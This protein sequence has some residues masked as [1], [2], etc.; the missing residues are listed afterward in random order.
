M[1]LFTIP[2]RKIGFLTVFTLCYLVTKAQTT[3]TWNQAG[4]GNWTTSTNWTPTRTTPATNDILVINNGGTKT[5]TSVPTQTIGRILISGNTN[6]TLTHTANANR[7]ITISN[8]TTAMDIASGSTLTLIGNTGGGTRT[9]TIQFTGSGNAVNIAGNLNLNTSQA[10]EYI[11]TNSVTTV[12]GTITN[13]GG[14]ITSTAANLSFAS[15]GT[16]V[17]ALNGSAIP[18][19]TWNAASNCN[20]TGITATVPTGLGQA[21]GNFTWNCAGHSTLIR[22]DGALTTVNGNF[23]VSDAG[24]FQNPSFIENGLSLTSNNALTLTIGGNFVISNAID[25]TWLILADGNGAVTV[26]VGGNFNM[27]GSTSYFIYH[28]A[29]TSSL[30]N[31]I[32]MNVSGNF[33]QSGGLIDFAYQTSTGATTQSL[34]RVAGNFSHS[35]TSILQ[36][37]TTDTD[38]PNGKIVFNKAGTQ[39]FSAATPANIGYTN[40]E[41][42]SGSTVELLSNVSLSSQATPAIWGGKFTVNS[43][44]ILDAG[45]FQLVSSTGATAGL[46]NE[47]TLSSSAGLITA[48]VNGIQNTTIGTISTSLATRTYSSAANYTYDG[49]AIQNSGIFT[50]SPTANQ[51]NNLTLNNTAGN[52][53]TGV[54]LQ[55]AFAVAGTLTLT[56]GHITSSSTNL[57]TMNAGSNVAGANYGTRISG[58]SDNSFVNGPIRKIGNTNFLFPVGK[59]N[60][61]HHFA[62][63]SSP[64]NPGD[65]YTTE[66]IRGSA[67]LLGTVSAVG[68]SHVSNCE[69]WDISTT[70]GSPNVD[71]TLSWTGTS[72]CNAAVYVNDLPSL[73]AAHFS[74]GTWS[75]YGGTVDGGSTASAGSLTWNGVT[76]FSPFSLGSTDKETNPLPV[77]LVNVKAYRSGNRNKIEWTNLTETAVDVYEVQRSVTGTSFET[78][79]SVAARSNTN[80]REDYF[81]FDPQT[82]P[83]TYYR[84]KVIGNDGKISYSPVVK[85]NG[86]DQDQ[87]QLVLYPNP[88]TGK[89]FTI[90]MNSPAG[91]Y[92]V[93][94]FGANGQV[95]KMETLKHPGGAYS[96]TIELPSQLQAGQYYLQVSGG[97]QMLT[98]KFI[99]Q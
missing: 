23:T 87:Q 56:S 63:I 36:T 42:L 81:G 17:H 22:L 97:E 71:V 28:F 21:F 55:Q 6:V 96:K 24:N 85:V 75:S 15:G 91:D 47:F 16:Y 62:G 66:Y 4:G 26:N 34:L 7:T 13:N 5:I 82:S 33:S 73:V 86:N 76:T 50:T 65:T 1:R 51:V 45:T 2:F 44:G 43:G 32:I 41:I 38:I 59:I 92:Q 67:R 54:T 80:A 48:N 98:T 12:T 37:S 61:G 3:Y 58:G 9:M 68:L 27:S 35:G 84:I 64:A 77:K 72:N 90:Q 74:G 20:I 46:N 57:L 39:T 11:A 95:V 19:A 40:Y 70:A 79:S 31:T 8:T 29:N 25:Y 94:I 10:G 99:I 89:Q 53:T 83:V 60:A 78:M 93:R 49:V 69:Y 52:T 88:V 30:L 14:T 18:T